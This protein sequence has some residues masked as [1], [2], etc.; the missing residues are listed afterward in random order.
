MQHDRAGS[1]HRF[2][3]DANAGTD[4]R[5]GPNGGPVFDGR[6]RDRR[7]P[8]LASRI[9]IIGESRIGTNE[10]I[11]TDA[12]SVPE[13]YATLDGRTISHDDIIFNKDMVA[14][15]TISPDARPR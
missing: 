11:V 15:I 9:L 5:V 13:L 6:T 8:G 12:E 3:A 2:P 10:H 14:D 1:H 7:L 4:R